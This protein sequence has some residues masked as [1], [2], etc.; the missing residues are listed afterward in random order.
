MLKISFRTK[1]TF[2]GS[3]ARVQKVKDFVECAYNT[4]AEI[5]YPVNKD[6]IDEELFLLKI[7]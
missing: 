3:T 1:G 7:H 2:T 5:I 6:E 4:F